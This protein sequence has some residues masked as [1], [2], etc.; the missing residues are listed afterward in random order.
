MKLPDGGKAFPLEDMRP[1][2]PPEKIAKILKINAD[3]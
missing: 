3:D 1:S 2:L